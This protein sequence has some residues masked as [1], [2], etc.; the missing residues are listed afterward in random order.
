MKSLN[1][2]KNAS[3]PK[4]DRKRVG[5]GIGS[6]VGK[7]CGRGQKGAGARSGY[8][9]RY[10]YEGGQARLFEK[11]P[12]RGFSRVRFQ[13]RCDVINLDQIEEIFQDGDEVS[14][15]TLREKGFISGPSYGIKVL[16]NGELTRKVTI[17]ARKISASAKAK[18]EA[19]GATVVLPE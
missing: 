7:T 1:T 6:G 18:C 15:E 12:T 5:R 19:S 11:L 4:K 2:L 9:R 8:K 14:L 13:K 16:G 17:K 3:R 10:S